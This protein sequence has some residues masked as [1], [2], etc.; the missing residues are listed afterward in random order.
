MQVC[1]YLHNEEE[2]KLKK[3]IWE[4]MNKEFLEAFDQLSHFFD[5][6]ECYIL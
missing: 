4:K 3:I 5:K 1:G 2:K 6:I